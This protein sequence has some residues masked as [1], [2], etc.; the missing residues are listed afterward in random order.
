MSGSFGASG[1]VPFSLSQP[2]PIQTGGGFAYPE[3]GLLTSNSNELILEINFPG[4]VTEDIVKNEITYQTL[5][6]PGG[7]GTYNLGWP[8]LP[9]FG[10][11]VAVPLGAEPQIEVLDYTLQRL[12][13]YNVYPVQEQLV[14]IAG[15]P[16]LSL[17]KM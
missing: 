5:F 6:I 8:E 16:N 1:W 12:S 7:G 4:M 3:V 9:T 10:R 11:F 2:A 13:G 17:S 14:D 15:A